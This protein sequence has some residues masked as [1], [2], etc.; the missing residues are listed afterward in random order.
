LGAV[1]AAIAEKN[2][3]LIITADH[4]NIEE[5][6]DLSSGRVDTEH[7][8]SQVPCWIW[9]LSSPLPEVRPEGM[10]ADVAPTI[11]ELFGIK[12]PEEM[13]GKSLFKK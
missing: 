11:L 10:L 7:S 6:K 1:A 2:G 13:T 9:R 8:K 5:M 4:G 3:T 12:Q